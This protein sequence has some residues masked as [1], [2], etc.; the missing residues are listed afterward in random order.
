MYF[1][2]GDSYNTPCVA[3]RDTLPKALFFG[4]CLRNSCK[5]LCRGCCGSG[6]AG[7]ACAGILGRR[8]RLGGLL[9]EFFAT[10]LRD[11]SGVTFL[12]FQMTL[13]KGH[14]ARNR[15][16]E[17]SSEG[18]DTS[19]DS[20][21]ATLSTVRFSSRLQA[22]RSLGARKW[23]PRNRVLVKSQLPTLVHTN[24]TEQPPDPSPGRKIAEHCFASKSPGTTCAKQSLLCFS[25][26]LLVCHGCLVFVRRAN[27]VLEPPT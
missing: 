12:P 25:M 13:L 23:I 3:L 14:S 9:E 16:F 2:Y 26:F 21:K 18:K 5:K 15:F 4:T 1:A 27:A 8:G 19:L 11:I 17:A 6:T 20:Q 10:L 7:D 22:M 24:H